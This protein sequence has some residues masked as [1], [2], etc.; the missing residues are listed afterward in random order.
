MIIAGRQRMLSSFGFKIQ[1]TH[2]GQGSRLSAC[3]AHVSRKGGVR[4]MAM[5]WTLALLA[6]LD[7][8]EAKARMMGLTF[9]ASR[10]LAYLLGFS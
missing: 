2:G 5:P 8:I 7:S 4:H 1:A 10:A 9:I 6:T 3:G